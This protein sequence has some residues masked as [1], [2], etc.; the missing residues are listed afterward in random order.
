MAQ[1]RG[2]LFKRL[3]SLFKSGPVVK[4]K[5]TS[6]RGSSTTKSSAIDVF[7]KSTSS[8]YGNALHSYGNYDRLSRLAEYSE[9]DSYSPEIHQSLNIYCLAGDN[10]IP[11]LDGTN[12]TI[13]ELYDNNNINFYV[14]SF[15][16]ENKKFV[17]G[18]CEKVMK[19]GENQQIY[20]VS[21]DD[22]SFVRLTENHLILLSDGTYVKVKDA[23][24]DMSV[25]AL[26]RT[27]SEKDKK[28]KL[29]GY[30]MIYQPSGVWEYTHRV[31]CDYFDPLTKGVCHHVNFKKRD[32]TPSNLQKMSYSEHQ[33][34][35]SHN[36]KKLW[37]NEE[38]S[39]KMK[40]IFS[41]RMIRIH[42]EPGFTKEFQRKAKE[43]IASYDKKTR[44]EKWGRNGS[45]NGMYGSARF[46]EKNPN[47]NKNFVRDF[48]KEEIIELINS[49]LK[50]DDACVLLKT[51]K[52]TLQSWMKKNDIKIW[53]KYAIRNKE[54]DFY[55]LDNL[56]KFVLE[57]KYRYINRN[58]KMLCDE[59]NIT[60]KECQILLKSNGYNGWNDFISKIN[61]KIISIEKD[62]VED[63]Y[64]LTIQKYHNFAVGMDG[65]FIMVHNSEESLAKDAK[66]KSLHI[67]SENKKIQ[68]ILEDLFFNVINFEFVGRS[69]VRNLCKYGDFFILT[70]VSPEYGVINCHPIPVN[71]IVREEGYDPE[72]PFS[73][74][75]RW[76][77]NGN[78]VLENWQVVHFRLNGNDAYMPYGSSIIDSARRV[79]R[80]LTLAEDSMLAY[81]V[82]RSPERRVFYIDV[83]NAPPDDVG[84]I[85]ESARSQL[86]T[87]SVVDKNDG[88]GDARYNSLAID[89]DYFI[90]VRGNESNTKI[91]TLPGGV[92]T[93]AIEDV[94]YL[95]SKLFAALGVPKPYLTFD[96]NLGSKASLAQLDL[97][98]SRAI[99]QIQ[100]VIISELNKIAAIHLYANGYDGDDLVNFNLYLSNP[101]TIA[102]QQKLELLRTR[103]EIA[104]SKPEGLLDSKF[105]YKE[106]MDLTD[107][108]IK[109]IKKGQIA[110]AKA[111]Q[112]IDQLAA[113]GGSAGSGV[114]GGGIDVGG[115]EFGGSGDF[116][117]G[118]FG[119]AGVGD[120]D[121]DGEGPD[122]DSGEDLEGDDSDE[123]EPDSLFAGNQ[124]KSGPLIKDS[125]E[126]SIE[127][128]SLPESEEYPVNKRSQISRTKHNRQRLRKSKGA[129]VN[130]MPKLS[131]MLNP[132]NQDF[133]DAYD[134]RSN[135]ARASGFAEGRKA[136]IDLSLRNSLK[137]IKRNISINNDNL[138]SEDLES[139]IEKDNNQEDE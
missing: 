62:G 126:D 127:L 70:D 99:N 23:H 77:S 119:D 66:G 60:T 117:L 128:E 84:N 115:S 59:L 109:E 44:D 93:T 38:Y 3:T 89:M 120:V 34:L 104:S 75:F 73:V 124:G 65:G 20:K 110:D 136:R 18:L 107:D 81:R 32:N 27:I 45:Q 91:D 112:G 118:D 37:E 123:E 122:L 135:Q 61:H 72:N 95:Q 129:S 42:K 131:D 103:F 97:R 52:K 16:I 90:P 24:K 100:Q 116:D 50:I 58:L 88:R 113:D 133:S 111:Q 17:P 11:L 105:I 114:V 43:K 21:F 30:E 13:K 57:R 101:S 130:M 35:H 8:V 92:N 78:Q 102:V 47:Y 6:L 4:K 19:T 86:K 9:M 108:E 41:E 25:R 22:G 40:K 132:S 12:K 79:F 1:D 68:K 36:Q 137:T 51:T 134:F 106:V 85:I 56:K 76:E 67:F 69:W 74:R 33:F 29:N 64:D 55:I 5:I 82:I 2:N 87:Q 26:Y 14:Y 71:E 15:D 98:F 138:L 54:Y 80:Q 46:G 49:D 10:T 53:A 125:E 121:V 96:E 63:V 39:S 83:G 31:V 139:K 7:R 48:N 94:Q 28:I